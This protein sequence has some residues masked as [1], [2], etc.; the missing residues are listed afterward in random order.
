MQRTPKLTWIG[1]V[2]LFDDHN[3]GQVEITM[4]PAIQIRPFATIGTHA[5]ALFGQATYSL[6]SR[7]SLTGG[8]RYTDEQKD[9]PQHWR[10]VPARDGHPRRSGSFYDFVDSATF[11]AWTPK[12]SVQVQASR[13]TFVYLSA[14]RGFKSGGFNPAAPRPGWPSARVRLEL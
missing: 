1:G 10:G 4:Y 5:W 2:F 8:V 9:H 6:S 11:D 7:V 14:T 13:D 12:A 3:E